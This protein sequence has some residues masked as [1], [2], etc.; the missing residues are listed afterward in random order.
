MYENRKCVNG[1]YETEYTKQDIRKWNVRNGR[2][3]TENAQTEYT[4][5]NIRIQ[6]IRKPN[7]RDGIY[8]TRIYVNGKYEMECTITENT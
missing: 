6:K 1:V 7:I 4:K 2:Y 5:R 8:E 3:K